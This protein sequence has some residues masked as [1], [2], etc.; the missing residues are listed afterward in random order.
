MS[1]RFKPT[2][3][4]LR[5]QNLKWMNFIVH[6][7]DIMCDCPNPLEHTIILI[8]QQEPELKFTPIEKDIIKKCITTDHGEEAGEEDVL[9]D[10]NLE[11]LFKEDFGDADTADTG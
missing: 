9:G 7:H 3:C 11:D 8:H 10:A 1:T 4:T 5:Q 6:A 2:K